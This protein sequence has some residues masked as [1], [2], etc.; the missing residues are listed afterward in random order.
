MSECDFNLILERARCV[1]C[2]YDQKTREALIVQL[3]CE[4][5]NQGGGGGG[6]VTQGT[7]PW[8]VLLTDG[9]DDLLIGPIEYKTDVVSAGGDT[10]IL[11]VAAGSK[12]QLY[13]VSFVPTVAAAVDQNVVV[14]IGTNSVTGWRTNFKGGGF[15]RSPKNGQGWWEGANGEDVIINLS[16]ADPIRYNLEYAIV[17]A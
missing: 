16:S 1:P 2:R 3:L 9:T 13:H 10:P 7:N 5:L 17:P 4:I 8:R 11:S 15:S 12:V 14:K 6:E